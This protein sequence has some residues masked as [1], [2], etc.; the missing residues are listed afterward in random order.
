[1]RCNCSGFSASQCDGPTVA[2]ATASVYALC[3]IECVPLY[4]TLG[5]NAIEYILNHA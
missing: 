2:A 4:D 5:E 3:S 1:M